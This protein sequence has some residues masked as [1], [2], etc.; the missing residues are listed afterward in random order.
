MSEVAGNV[1]PPVTAGVRLSQASVSAARALVAAS[2]AAHAKASPV[3]R[4]ENVIVCPSL[5]QQVA[6]ALHDRLRCGVKAVD[7]ILHVLAVLGR[8]R[9]LAL[10]GLGDE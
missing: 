3:H 7:Q 6:D 8:Q 4:V 10:F 9:E 5:F 1:G 2:S